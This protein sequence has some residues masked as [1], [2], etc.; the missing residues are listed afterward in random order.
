MFNHYNCLVYQVCKNLAREKEPFEHVFETLD[1]VYDTSKALACAIVEGIAMLVVNLTYCYISVQVDDE[2]H[3]FVQVIENARPTPDLTRSPIPAVRYAGLDDMDFQDVQVA[4]KERGLRD[5]TMKEW[6]I[7]F[8]LRNERQDRAAVL[9]G[10]QKHGVDGETERRLDKEKGLAG[11]GT[12]RD[13]DG[14][15][16]R[17]PTDGMNNYSNG[18]MI[19]SPLKREWSD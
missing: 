9:D 10:G 15:V 16:K 8:I 1:M 14:E 4:A 12:H 3:P 2:V 11:I 18:Q 19:G 7:G 5:S 6:L 13:Q 17:P